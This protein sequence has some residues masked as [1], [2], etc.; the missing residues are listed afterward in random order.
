MDQGPPHKTRYTETNR[1]WG[2][3]SNTW[4]KFLNRTSMDYT[5]RSRIDKWDFIKLQSF[6]K[7]KDTVNRRKWHPINWENIF[8]NPTSDRGLIKAH[9]TMFNTLSLQRNAN[10]HNAEILLHTSQNGQVKN[11]GDSRC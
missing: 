11:L 6:Y 10:Q 8:T 9:K 5:L 1:K 7:A 4:A 2:K 3:A